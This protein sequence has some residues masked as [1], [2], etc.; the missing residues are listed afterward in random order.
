MRDEFDSHN[1]LGKS[2]ALFP[3][4][5]P[6]GSEANYLLVIRMCFKVL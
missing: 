1:I 2:L 6:S 4:Q 3:G 5:C